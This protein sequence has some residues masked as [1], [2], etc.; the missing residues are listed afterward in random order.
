MRTTERIRGLYAV[1]PDVDEDARL[2]AL[3]KAALAGGTK[4]L[5]YRD[6]RLD[7]THRAQRARQLRELCAQ[8]GALFIMNDDPVLA[9][10]IGADG[11]HLGRDDGDISAARAKVGGDV[12]IG[13]SCYDEL[14]RARDAVT[15]GADYVAF[16]SVFASH[17]KPKAVNASLDLIRQ[18][19]QEIPVPIVA[20]GG[21]DLSNAEQVFRAGAHALAV[22]TALYCA[23]DVSA[24]AR[25]FNALMPPI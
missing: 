11:V 12:L 1:T 7:I 20:I 10:E 15:Q 16:G 14:Q 19:R 22:I 2:L 4:L 3:V 6:K 5:Q 17:V 24:A 25:A 9:A 23:E 8:S 21:I 13:V 18:A